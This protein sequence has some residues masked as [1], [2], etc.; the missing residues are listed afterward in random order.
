MKKR[1][2]FLLVFFVVALVTFAQQGLTITGNVVEASTNE[3]MPGVTVKVEGKTTATATDINGNYSITVDRGDVLSFSFL[4]MQTFSV[5]VTSDNPINVQLKD[6][7]VLLDQVVVIGYGTVKKSELTGAVSSIGSKDLMADV[8][9][10]AAGALQ[11]KI[12][13]VSV[14]N[15]TATPGEGMS[16][17]VRGITS[18]NSNDPLYVID[19]VYGDINLIDPADIQSIEVLKDASAAAIYGSRAASGVVLITTKS[20]R[21]NTPAKLDLNVYA[22]IQQISKKLD[23]MNAPEWVNFMKNNGYAENI[24]RSR[25]AGSYKGNGTNWQ[26]ELYQTAAVY[27]ANLNISGGSESSVYSASVGYLNQEG[28]MKNSGYDALNVRLKNEFSFLDGRLKIGE[29]LVFKTDKRRG[30]SDHAT[31]QDAL[32]LSPVIPVYDSEHPLGGWGHVEEWM[33]NMGNPVGSTTV[34]VDNRK[35][36]EVL[37]NAYAQIELFAGLKYKLNFGLNQAQ[38]NN[39]TITGVYDFGRGGKNDLPD[40]SE[41]S[42]NYKTWLLEHTLNYDRTFG[43]HTVSGLLG[44][45]AQKNK[46]RGISAARLDLPLGTDAIGAG[47]SDQASNGG[48]AYNSGLLSYFGRVM[49]SYDSRYMLSASVRRDGS[50]KFEDGHRWGSYPSFSLGWNIHN[51]SF[52]TG[53]RTVVDEL[54][55][56]VS[57]GK[58][59]NQNIDD[60]LTKR[61]L[62]QYMNYVQGTQWWMGGIT[63]SA[64]VSP[65]DLTWETT[66]T[67]NIG[68]DATFLG[69]KL[70]VTADAFIQKTKDVLMPVSMPAST[71]LTGTPTMNAG[72]IENKGFEMA[73]T[74]RNNV[75]KVYYSLT[76]NMSTISNKVKKITV[77]NERELEGYKPQGLGTITWFKTGEPM[78]VFRL[79]K[80]DGIFQSQ[81]EIDEYKRQNN[82][83]EG[84]KAE[85]GDIRFVDY[86]GDGQIN[87]DDRQTV[88]KPLPDVSFGLRGNVEWNGFD[89][90]FFFDGMVGNSIYNF[91][92]YRMENMLV[93]ENFSKDVLGAWTSSNPSSSMPRFGGN[94]NNARVN[95]DRWLEKGD[96]LRLKTFEIGYTLPKV[97]TQKV[98][99]DKVRIYALFDNLFTIT[100]Y[101]G[102][103]P[104]IGYNPNDNNQSGYSALTR[105]TDHGRYPQARAFSFG[106]Q[107]GL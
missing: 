82:M 63:G 76:G 72:T 22:G 46:E 43:K 11:G 10:S 30:S 95:S 4:G 84:F 44:Y 40:L 21:K 26:D 83:N 98:S 79:I 18:L 77:G 67:S 60:Y 38:Q 50:S 25:Y 28:I 65:R 7:N 64:W 23:V 49:Y 103:T 85:P 9:T 52:A 41:S 53:M 39:K 31:V 36:M 104:D 91:T 62:S 68:L 6:D 24:E 94:S 100:G 35:R 54:K 2:S 105:G 87:D 59:G 66:E 16:I 106:V 1:I 75:G 51:E 73:I 8:A 12:P 17:T 81:A 74:H 80:T 32:R 107:I 45:S 3:P 19:G 56:R 69:G 96:F 102:Y 90:N 5:T 14:S 86:N 97:L 61:L 92:R 71:G 101:K 70:A 29:S 42:R 27:K 33:N 15:I 34:N 55:L 78:G 99:L 37:F 57:Y 47:P 89:A 13:G 93:V 20:G 58:L 88:G 48:S